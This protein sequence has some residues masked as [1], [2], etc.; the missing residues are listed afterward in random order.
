[1]LLFV[2]FN[3]PLSPSGKSLSETGDGDRRPSSASASI[4]ITVNNSSVESNGSHPELSMSI[5]E[6]NSLSS[7]ANSSSALSPR[8]LDFSNS[9]RDMKLTPSSR[10]VPQNL[11][12]L[13]GLSVKSPDR[14]I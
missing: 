1:M 9:K 2:A 5:S 8:S 14:Y 11:P 10:K 4:G 3:L 13:P 7:A 12:S 6:D